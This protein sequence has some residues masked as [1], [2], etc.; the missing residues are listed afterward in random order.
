[1]SKIWVHARV[2]IC[3]G[4]EGPIPRF[5]EGF[6][7]YDRRKYAVGN[8]EEAVLMPLLVVGKEHKEGA[9]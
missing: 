9:A 8:D 5:A 3:I 2:T 6:A 7:R 4:D 1:M